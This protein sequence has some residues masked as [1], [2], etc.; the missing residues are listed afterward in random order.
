MT[1]KLKVLTKAPFVESVKG[2]EWVLMAKE[3]KPTD[4]VN[5]NDS[6][7]ASVMLVPRTQWLRES[8]WR[9]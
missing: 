2:T 4:Y 1:P 5:Y 6:S 8:S 7:P 3:V 9:S